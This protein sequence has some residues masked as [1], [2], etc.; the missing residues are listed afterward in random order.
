MLIGQKASARTLRRDLRGDR[1]N[2]APMHAEGDNHDI[3]TGGCHALA[4]SGQA[5]HWAG[6]AV[7]EILTMQP[8]DGLGL[9]RLLLQRSPYLSCPRRTARVKAFIEPVERLE[10]EKKGDR[11]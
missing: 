11:R 3:S 2:V 8:A 7:E 10:N 5:P 4:V 9:A 6:G 1:K